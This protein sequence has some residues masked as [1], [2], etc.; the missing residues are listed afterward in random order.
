MRLILAAS[1]FAIVTLVSV[2]ANA[3]DKGPHTCPATTTAI[4]VV[5]AKGQDG[6]TACKF[7][8]GWHIQLD[9]GDQAVPGPKGVVCIINAN[10]PSDKKCCPNIPKKA[11]VTGRDGRPQDEGMQVRCGDKNNPNESSTDIYVALIDD[12]TKMPK[13]GTD[14]RLKFRILT[15]RILLPVEVVVVVVL[16]V[17]AGEPA[18]RAPKHEGLILEQTHVGGGANG[19]ST[20]QSTTGTLNLDLKLG[21]SA[22]SKPPTDLTCDKS[23]YCQEINIL[24]HVYKYSMDGDKPE[25]KDD[26]KGKKTTYKQIPTAKIPQWKNASVV[27]PPLKPKHLSTQAKVQKQN[28]RINRLSQIIVAP[29]THTPIPV[30]LHRMRG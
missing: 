19:T 15:M 10:S 13:H 29:N 20:D 5:A 2:T 25:F 27:R 26:Y 9:D 23:S 1:T 7:S 18:K 28:P 12:K 22:S 21:K 14:T 30:I 11:N 3:Q 17:A 16:V 4:S 24:D 8:D 6:L